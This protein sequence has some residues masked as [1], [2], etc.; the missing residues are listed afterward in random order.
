M[1]VYMY[2]SFDC[3]S[4]EELSTVKGY[5]EALGLEVE[6]AGLHIDVSVDY[7]Q[8][9]PYI[10]EDDTSHVAVA[11]KRWEALA[12]MLGRDFSVFG[13]IDTSYTAGEYMDFRI[14]YKDGKFT[15][16]YSDWYQHGDLDEFE[17][18]AELCENLGV[19]CTAE[20]YERL[21]DKTTFIIEQENGDVVAE[22]VPLI[23]RL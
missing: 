21:R 6:M 16:F 15:T 23:Y 22:E 8:I 13:V 17:D 11:Y 7:T 9:E 10:I 3:I 20:E 12:P 18:Y 1:R 2:Y 14:D 19:I 5:F 4:E